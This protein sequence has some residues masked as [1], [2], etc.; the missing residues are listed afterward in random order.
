[1]PAEDL[2][3][4]PKYPSTSELIEHLKEKGYVYDLKLDEDCLTYEGGKQKLMP[5]DF[6]IDRVYRYEGF[7]NPSDEEIVYAISSETHNLKGYLHDAFG[8]YT[9]TLNAKMI[10][11]LRTHPDQFMDGE[12]D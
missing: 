2:N 8:V 5:Q 10:E 11:K 1:M 12:E 6:C 9:D 7:T 4:H 3:Q